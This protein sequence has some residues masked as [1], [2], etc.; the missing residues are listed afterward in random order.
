MPNFDV[1]RAPS[2]GVRMKP[3]LV[4]RIEDAY[5]VPDQSSAA[6][7]TLACGGSTL[8]RYRRHAIDAEDPHD[9][10]D[11]V[12]LTFDV[13]PPTWDGNSDPITGQAAWYDVRVRIYKAQD[14]EPEHTE[15]KMR[16]LLGSTKELA[17]QLAA[18]YGRTLACEFGPL[19]L[20]A[21]REAMIA[22]EVQGL[23]EV[24][25]GSGA[26]VR[27]LPGKQVEHPERTPVGSARR[28]VVVVTNEATGEQRLVKAADVA[29]VTAAMPSATKVRSAGVD[30]KT[31]GDIK[32]A[33]KQAS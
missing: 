9:F 22:L 18:Q 30:A 27:R 24:R 20:K 13:T 14:D 1:I 25:V 6:T 2:T 4:T 31:A 17:K 11:D 23:V 16:D 10:F 29:T 28:A 5:G 21:V 33:A 8:K 19:R 12:G 26:Y 32:A 3:R 7:I 15:Q